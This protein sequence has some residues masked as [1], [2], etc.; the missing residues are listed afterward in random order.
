MKSAATAST[1]ALKAYET[2]NAELASFTKNHLAELQAAETAN[3]S[4]TSGTDPALASDPQ[5]GAYPQRPPRTVVNP[6][7]IEVHDQFEKL[8]IRRA[9]L[10]TTMLPSH[11]AVQAIDSSIADVELQLTSIVKEILAP[12][13]TLINQSPTTSQPSAPEGNIAATQQFRDSPKTAVPIAAQ[14]EAKEQYRKLSDQLDLAQQKYD[15]ALKRENAAREREQ[16]AAPT[17]S[18]RSRPRRNRRMLTHA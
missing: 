6:R 5:S 18:Q 4:V 9:E 17:I 15:D 14:R 13:E 2:A 3:D 16:K 1:G 8:L 10:L 12:V 11:P 7:W